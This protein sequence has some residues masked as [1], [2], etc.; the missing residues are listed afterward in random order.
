MDASRTPQYPRRMS[1]VEPKDRLYTAEEYARLPDYPDARDELVRGQR[2]REPLPRPIHAQVQ[3]RL[4]ELLGA[5]VRAHRL[6][7]VGGETGFK[8]ERDP[9]TVRGP[10]V[11]FLSRARVGD[12]IPEHWPE[13]GPDL[14][15]EIRSPSDRRRG[16]AEKIGQY[17]AAGTRLVWVVDPKR[18]TAVVYHSP[19]D[20]RV[21]RVCDALDGEEVVP[22]FRCEVRDLFE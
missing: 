4:C 16:L 5:H 12:T 22:G 10:D 9:D 18:R 2:V 15:V 21:L 20:A 6:G 3:A 14:A 1:R 17:F 7:F 8:L 19:D 11:A 13:H